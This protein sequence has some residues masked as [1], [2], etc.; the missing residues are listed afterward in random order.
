VPVFTRVPA[1]ATVLTFKLDGTA[2]ASR[3]GFA[4]RFASNTAGLAFAGAT[5]TYTAP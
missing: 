5:Y 1:G 3:E 4:Y 2:G